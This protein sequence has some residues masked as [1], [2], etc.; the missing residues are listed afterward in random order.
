MVND[1]EHLCMSFF[2]VRRID[3]F[4]FQR[5]LTIFEK[6]EARIYCVEK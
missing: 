5:F 4:H 2:S 3:V 1:T 6:A